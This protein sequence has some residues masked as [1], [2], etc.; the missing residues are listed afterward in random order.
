LSVATRVLGGG[1]TA[2]DQPIGNR[3]ARDRAGYVHA[4]FF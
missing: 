4:I 2:L 1:A 3:L